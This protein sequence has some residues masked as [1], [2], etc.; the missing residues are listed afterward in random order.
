MGLLVLYI[1]D[2][3]GRN[4]ARQVNTII[5]KVFSRN[6]CL[7]CYA[8]SKFSVCFEVHIHVNTIAVRSSFAPRDIGKILDIT[9]QL[10]PLIHRN[11]IC[12]D[13]G[14]VVL[15]LALSQSKWKKRE[16]HGKL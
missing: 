1:L 13:E 3:A 9:N 15:L 14:R 2:T 12:G 10:L 16:R 4:F 7:R 8:R 5:R 11:R 6:V